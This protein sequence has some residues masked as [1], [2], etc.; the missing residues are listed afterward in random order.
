MKFWYGRKSWTGRPEARCC[1]FGFD[2]VGG[3]TE[4]LWR[5]DRGFRPEFDNRDTGAC[6]SDDCRRLKYS[7]RPEM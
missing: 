3:Q 5:A 6:F 1:H 2:L 7:G 4:V